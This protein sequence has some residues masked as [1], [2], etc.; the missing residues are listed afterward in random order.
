MKDREEVDQPGA[1]QAGMLGTILLREE[2]CW[3]KITQEQPEGLD[4]AA[5]D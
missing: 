3:R 2:G 4:T 1:S 5:G